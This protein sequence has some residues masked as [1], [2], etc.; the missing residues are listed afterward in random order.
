MLDV[1]TMDGEHLDAFTRSLTEAGASR[2]QVLT[3]VAGSTLATL[4]TALG[5]AVAAYLS[6]RAGV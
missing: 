4:A 5:F 3:G 2:R 6:L 1:R